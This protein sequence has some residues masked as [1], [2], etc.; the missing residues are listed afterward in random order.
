MITSKEKILEALS[1]IIHPEKGKDIVTLGMISEIEADEKGIS[2]VIIPEKSNDPFISSIKSTVARTIKDVLGPDEVINEIKVQPKILVGKTREKERDILPGVTNIVAVSSGKGG[3]GKTTIAVNLAI[4]LARKGFNV[5]LL[6][7]DVYGPSV[8]KMFNEE[9]YRP[10]VRRENNADFITPLTKHGVKVLSTGFFV[11][12]SDA[13]VWRGP[14]ASNFLKQLIT[15]GEWGRLDYLLVDLPP[16]TSDIH[17]TLVQE[18]PVTGAIVITTPQEVALAD[19]VKGISMFRSDKIDVP[20][21]GLVENMSWFTPAELPFNKYYI[22]GKDGG[23]KLA[24][25]MDVPFLGQIPLVQ[26]ICEGSDNGEPAALTDSITGIAF[27]ELAGELV[28]RVD[29][30]NKDQRPTV[31]LQI[32]K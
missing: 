21:L 2:L 23:K 19:A 30:R 20:V 17:L 14:M 15:Q 24:E 5:G 11:D 13:V 22:F 9:K 12:P 6:D 3:V 31:K 25:K 1:K 4:A 16:G 7:A 27:M 32:T 29:H 18:V 8:P 10:V 28:K 26:S